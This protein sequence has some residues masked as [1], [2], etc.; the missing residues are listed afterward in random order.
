MDSDLLNID[1]VAG[2]AEDQA[3]FHSPRKPFGLYRNLL[4]VLAREIDKM[5]IFCAN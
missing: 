3:G 2:A 4:L 1:A 5:I